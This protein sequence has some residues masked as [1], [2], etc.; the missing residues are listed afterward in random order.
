M[1]DIEVGRCAIAP[2][3]RGVVEGELSEQK[4]LKLENTEPLYALFSSDPVACAHML[5]NLEDAFAPYC[6][7]YA[8]GT[9]ERLDATVLVY[10]AYRIPLVTT[11]GQAGGV[12]EVLSTFHGQLPGRAVVHIQPHHLGASDRV[13]EADTLAPILRLALEREHFVAAET[14]SVEI[15]AL[16]HRSTGEIIE[17]YQYYPDNFFEPYQLD[18]GRFYGARVEGRLVSVTGV[19]SV[20]E[21]AKI[22][23]LG[24]LVTHPDFRGRGLSTACTSHLCARLLESG[25]DLMALNVRR[26]NRSAVRVY[27]KLGFR[28]HDTYLEGFADKA[29]KPTQGHLL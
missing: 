14:A 9:E 8:Y 4:A 19:H 24:H 13:Y 3:Y 23:T 15:E 20:S 2:S 26:Q 5:A 6:D 22:A 7:W 12:Q 10:T 25:I 16:T 11:Y 28:Y 29:G 21:R 1:G 17:L 18:S 27:E